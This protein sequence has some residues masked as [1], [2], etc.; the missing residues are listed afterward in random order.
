MTPGPRGA[1]HLWLRDRNG[2]DQSKIWT[3]DLRVAK[4]ATHNYAIMP[5]LHVSAYLASILSMFAIIIIIRKSIYTVSR[6]NTTRGIIIIRK[7]IYT[8]FRANTTRGIILFISVFI[9][10][11]YLYLY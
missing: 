9:L 1:E 10:F 11:L 7:S 5:H 8:V 3:R 6:A 2:S 4:L